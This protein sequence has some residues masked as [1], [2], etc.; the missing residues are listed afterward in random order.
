M[1]PVFQ[2]RKGFGQGNCVWACIAS[3]FEI[4]LD[5]LRYP[6]P[7][8][9]DVLAWTKEHYPALEFHNVDLGFDYRLRDVPGIPEGEQRWHYRLRRKWEPPTD[10]YWIASVDSQGLMRPVEDPYYPMPALHA[11]VMKGRDLVHDPNDS[12]PLGSY[13]PKVVMQSWWS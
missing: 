9:E 7:F 2:D 5:T 11:V 8:T 6:P 10:D 13:K 12:Y 4:P 3:I 1:K